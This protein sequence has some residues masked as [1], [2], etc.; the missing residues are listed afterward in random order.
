MGPTCIWDS[1]V[2]ITVYSQNILTVVLLPGFQCVITWKSCGFV[3][4]KAYSLFLMR[5]CP[6]FLVL[7]LEPSEAATDNV[8]SENELHPVY[9]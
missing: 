6:H 1:F 2:F 4:A 3:K 7:N 8:H 9:N 5:V